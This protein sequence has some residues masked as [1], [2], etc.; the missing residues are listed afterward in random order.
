MKITIFGTGYVGLV[1]GTCLAEVGHE[2][3][4]VDINEE[5]IENLKEGI[6]PIY[7]PW[8]SELVLRN[9]R[10][11]R[12]NFTT[13]ASVGVEFAQV[14]MSAVGT[15]PDA[16]HR[17]DLQYVREVART[18]G[19]HM[20]GYTVFINKSTVPVG[21]GKLCSDIIQKELDARGVDI[22]YDVV[23]NPEF[24]KEWSAIKDFMTP[25]R[26]VC[27]L[28]S[29]RAQS[30]MEELYKPFVRTTAPLLFTSLESAEIIKYASN[31]FLATKISFINEI[32]NF[33]ELVWANIW[34]ISRCVGMDER[35]GSRFLHAGIGYGG[36]CFP[37]DVQA[38]IETG[39]DYGYD[40]QIIRATEQVNEKQ[41]TRVITKLLQHIPDLT[42]KKIALW[43][44]SFKPKTDD[45]RDAASHEVIKSLLANQVSEIRTFDPV[46]KPQ[47]AR[48]Y[49]DES[50]VLFADTSYHALE[51]AD[52]L[53][54]LTE[55]DEFRAVDLDRVKSLLRSPLVIDGRNIWNRKELESRGFT[56][57]CIGK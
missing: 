4:C 50:R 40:F 43:G 15:P 8:L 44:L 3:M 36:S 47:M 18:V 24:L 51:Q 10:E 14:I 19:E 7:E 49:Q 27:G 30:L 11:K 25:D 21:T 37:K 29:P 42:G 34:D 38:L 26:I 20:T 32:A 46:S 13:Q 35:I 56:Y 6:I 12:L 5:K 31:A 54:I 1:T 9:Y 53:I 17:A 55:W 23:S 52:A 16:N 45:V 41:K 57:E 39:K 48:I 28:S 33:A 22:A 2:V